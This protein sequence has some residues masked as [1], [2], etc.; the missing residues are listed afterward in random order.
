[1]PFRQAQ[2]PEQSRRAAGQFEAAQQ[3]GHGGDFVALCCRAELAEHEP[4]AR[5]PGADQMHGAAART[6]AA[7]Q[8]F[9]VEGD[10][11]AQRINLAGQRSAQ[12]RGPGGEGLGELR[13]IQRGEDAPEGVVTGDAVGQFEQVPE[14]VALGLAEFLEVHEALRAAEPFRQAQGPEPAEGQRADGDEQNVVERV[15]FGAR[16]ARVFELME[17]M[18]EADVFEHRK[19][20]PTQPLKVHIIVNIMKMA[21]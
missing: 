5:G 18:A 12:P 2:G 15:A 20:V 16:D 19:L 1:M 10:S 13:G 3:F 21:L 17:V 4:V 7:P 9:A 8:G 6:A 14:P 11:R